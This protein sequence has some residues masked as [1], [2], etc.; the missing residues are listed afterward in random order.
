MKRITALTSGDFKNITRDSIL[1]L[2]TF[3]PF[4][5]GLL[6]RFGM[7]FAREALLEYFDLA[8]HYV[9]IMSFLI[10]MTP[11]MY[12]TVMG[13]IILDDRDEDILTYISV[14]P[15]SR[16]GYV[17]YRL[18]SPMVSS[19]ILTFVVLFLGG[20][21][22]LHPMGTIPV[23][24]MASLEAPLMTLVLG[25]FAANKVEGLAISKGLGLL[26]F[27]P[28]AAYFIKSDWQLLAGILPPYWIT[29]AFLSIYMNYEGYW[30]Y[31][32]CGLTVHILLILVMLKRFNKRIS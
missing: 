13:F 18:M 15:L 7:P 9:F 10:L 29:K 25:T 1:L 17:L 21:V 4:F 26:N 30:I 14:T 24:I 28:V 31:I 22:E 20:L 6:A 27:A 19:F 12:G 16:Q 5:I 8:E 32:I 11:M 3:I 23:A 2:V